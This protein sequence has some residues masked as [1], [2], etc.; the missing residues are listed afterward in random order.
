MLLEAPPKI[1]PMQTQ[2]VTLTLPILP[3][4]LENRQQAEAV[5]AQQGTPLRWAIVGLDRDRQTLTVEAIVLTED[6]APASVS[7]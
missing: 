6:P 3:T 4:P 7:G 1:H 5:V 2:F